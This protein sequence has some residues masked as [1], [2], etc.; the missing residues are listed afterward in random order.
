MPVISIIVPVFNAANTL[1]RCINSI[2]RQSFDDF[3]LIIVND[4]SEDESGL[5]I[6]EYSVIDN[7]IR[8]IDYNPNKGVSFARNCGLA[9]SKGEYV[10]FADSDDY[11]DENWCRRLLETQKCMP[12]FNI[13][14]NVSK[15]Y[16]NRTEDVSSEMNSRELDDY[17]ELFS[18]GLSGFPVNKIYVNSIIKS[19]SI[20]F[21]TDIS[22]G[23]DVLFN[24]DYYK[25][26]TN[27]YYY[28]SDC[29]YY[30]VQNNSS[31]L[32]KYNE[33]WLGLHL[34]PFSC[35]L[36]LIRY[37]RV[38]DY[39]DNWFSFFVK[40]FDNVFDRRCKRSFWWKISYNQSV[41][42][43]KE[44]KFCFEH[45]SG[46]KDSPLFLRIVGIYNYFILWMYQRIV[47]LV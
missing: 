8:I 35:R 6:S 2:L 32:N 45:I 34:L 17:Y 15:R 21:R 23:E 36:P 44:F 42:K 10:M 22:I 12:N 28:I 38:Q 27:Q 46:E 40:S 37:D 43:S 11:V 29:L 25:V 3:E 26:S 19:N 1:K 16:L 33:N 14:C 4:G 18:M 41:M 47:S 20:S 31:A 7:R 24:V 39:C 13:I 9:V 30:Y 5:I